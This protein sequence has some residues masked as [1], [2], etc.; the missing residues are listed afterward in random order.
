MIIKQRDP[1]THLVGNSSGQILGFADWQCSRLISDIYT[2]VHPRDTS[3]VGD[4]KS[5]GL[6]FKKLLL[7]LL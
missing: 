2:P 7:L 6:S 5:C 4:K 3:F 1:S